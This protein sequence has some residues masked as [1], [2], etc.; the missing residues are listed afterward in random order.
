[1]RNLLTYTQFISEGLSPNHHVKL[2]AAAASTDPLKG[3]KDSEL[4]VVS[5]SGDNI[6]VK[7]VEGNVKKVKAS[8]LTPI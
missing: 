4:V 5:V 7:D 1:M 6:E 3:W 8:D 2:T